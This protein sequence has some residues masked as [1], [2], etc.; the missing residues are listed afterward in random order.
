MI[1]HASSSVQPAFSNRSMSWMSASLC[2][3]V[4][5]SSVSAPRLTIRCTRHVISAPPAARMIT[6]SSMPMPV[7]VIDLTQR[8][9]RIAPLMHA[10]LSRNVREVLH[11]RERAQLPQGAL[12]DLPDA[13]PRHAEDLADFFQR[14]RRPSVEAVAELEH[15]ALAQ[16]QG[17]ERL[18][19]R[20]YAGIVVGDVLRQ[21]S[22]VGEEVPELRFVLIADRLL[23]RDGRL[24]AAHDLLHLVERQVEVERDLE[25]QRLPAELGLQLALRAHDL[26]Q[27][28]DDVH[29]HA[30]RARLV[31]ERTRHR[32]ADPPGRVRRELEALAPVEF[33]RRAH[34][35]DRAFL[36]QI[37]ER[38]TL[39][40]IALRDRHDQAKIGLDHGLLR[41][42]VAALD[43]LGQLDLLGGGKQVDLANLLQEELE[44]IHVGC[45]RVHHVGGVTCHRTSSPRSPDGGRRQHAIDP[46]PLRPNSSRR[47]VRLNRD[48]WVDVRPDAVRL[49]SRA[50]RESVAA[51]LE[52]GL[53]AFLQVSDR[54]G[55][56]TFHPP[57]PRSPHPGGAANAQGADTTRS[58]AYRPVATPLHGAYGV[59]GQAPQR[60]SRLARAR[61]ARTSRRF[62]YV[63]LRP[64]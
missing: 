31:G 7:L 26:V 61:R 1:I 6:V 54:D 37:E 60:P 32:L 22:T 14:R 34:Q 57:S 36:D 58:G 25:G 24:R 13:L 46:Q 30:D 8:L 9:R 3:I 52:R 16:S 47:E 62:A 20:A 5:A 53:A 43:A 41:A 21:R 11:F 63:P 2:A 12:L 17:R 15:A 42:V 19:Q 51:A 4:A 50:F 45:N 35:P 27:L 18:N 29:R 33:L 55:G 40:A 28:L 49:E 23:E 38:Q 64:W 48:L 59:C 56:R 44:R 10:E 39:V